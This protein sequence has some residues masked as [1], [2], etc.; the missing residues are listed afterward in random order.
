M[1]DLEADFAIE[2][3]LAGDLERKVRVKDAVIEE[4]RADFLNIAE[5]CAMVS[6]SPDSMERER[7]FMA[8]RK[9]ADENTGR[10]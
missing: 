8:I 4:M 6:I 1:T 3:K 10:A 2:K 7:A 5:L 9:I